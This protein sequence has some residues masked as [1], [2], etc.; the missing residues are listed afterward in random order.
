MKCRRPRWG[1]TGFLAHRAK[2]VRMK[3]YGA[4]FQKRR[5]QREILTN[6]S[7]EQM[8]AGFEAALRYVTLAQCDR[9]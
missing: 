6:G 9:A 5:A 2:S 7:M 1:R 3:S 4:G 8:C